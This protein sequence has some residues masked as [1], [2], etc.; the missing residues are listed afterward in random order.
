M[1]VVSS[2]DSI[3]SNVV[4]VGVNYLSDERDNPKE[5]SPEVVKCQ[6]SLGYRHFVNHSIVLR[7]LGTHMQAQ[8]EDQAVTTCH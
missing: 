1:V 5:I 3:L 4:I 2:I 8:V 6:I 7:D